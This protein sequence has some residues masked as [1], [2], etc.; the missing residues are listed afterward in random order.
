M[1]TGTQL[2]KSAPANQGQFS[3]NPASWTGRLAA[4]WDVARIRWT[5]LEPA[6]RRWALTV[7][8]LLVA[9]IGGLLWYGLRPDWRTLYADL[10]PEDARQT[11]LILT[12]AQIP[13]DVTANGAGIRV[14]ADQLDKARLATA[15]KGGIKSGR[16]GFEIFDKPNWVGSEFD[17][18]VNYQRALEGELEHTVGSLTDVESARVHLVLAHD[19]LFREQERPAKASVVLKLRHR[20]LAD[21]EPEAIRNLVASAVDGLTPDRVVLVDAAGHLPLGPKTAEQERLTAEEALEE[22]LVSTLEPVTGAGNVRASVTLDYDA[23]A[24]D[25]TQETYDPNQTVTLSMQRTEQTTG[26]QPVAAGVPGTASNA[27]N[28]QALPVYPQQTTPPQSAKTESGTYGASKTVKHVMENP[29]RVRRMTAAIVVNDRMMQL[30]T[31]AR[32]AVWQPRSADELRNLTVLAQAAVGFDPARGDML[33]VQDLAF[34]DNRTAQPIS[35]P[36]QMLATA[37]NSPV[38][39]KYAA[40]L[41]GLLVVLAFGVRPALRRAALQ[42]AAKELTAG[43]A[44]VAQPVLKPPEPAE[45]DP[46]RI[47]AQEIFDQVS[48]HLKREPSQSSRLLQSWIHS[49]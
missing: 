15:A 31:R 48:G 46:E 26:P 22:K 40:L 43:A 44:A 41:A 12:Q 23:A 8:A 34:E 3:R 36:G 27:P 16:M 1:A 11:G 28:S 13:Y 5:T 35:L 33:T 38:L 24:T 2:E 29:G 39:V 32:A 7:A 9:M 45:L 10:D 6:Q 25:E 30:A 14:P 37:E 4:L 17:E 49:D 18:Q 47:R 19:S 42:P 21:G 20:N